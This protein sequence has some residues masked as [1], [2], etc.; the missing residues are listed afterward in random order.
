MTVKPCIVDECVDYGC[1]LSSPVHPLMNPRAAQEQCSRA[2]V[3]RPGGCIVTSCSR[4]A[5]E[6]LR[7]VLNRY[8]LFIEIHLNV[9]Q[10]SRA[11]IFYSK[12]KQAVTVH[13]FT[14][15]DVVCHS[16]CDID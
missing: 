10:Y 12:Q 16:F 1:L 11:K 13:I 5:A 14:T 9:M 4:A 8:S 6:F 15:N 7:D 3:S 2:V